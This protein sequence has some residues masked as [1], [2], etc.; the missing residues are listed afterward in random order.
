PGIGFIPGALIGG[1]IGAG[2]QMAG[3]MS[4]ITGGITGLVSTG[5][6]AAMSLGSGIVTGGLMGA[7]GIGGAAAVV[8]AFIATTV[9]NSAMFNPEDKQVGGDLGPQLVEVIKTVNKA[10]LTN[11]EAKTATVKYVIALS[12]SYAISGA[13]YSDTIT[14]IKTSGPVKTLTRQITGDNVLASEDLVLSSLGIDLSDSMVVNSVS[15]TGNVMEDGK[16]TAFGPVTGGTTV[17]IGTAPAI[18]FSCPLV[19]S[20]GIACVSQNGP[21]Q[22]SCHHCDPSYMKS[23]F[24]PACGYKGNFSAM[25]VMGQ[26]GQPVYLPSLNGKEIAWVYVRTGTD[27]DGQNSRIFKAGEYILELHHMKV[28]RTLD[29]Q[30][31]GKTL[32]SGVMVGNLAAFPSGK[33]TP[34]SHMQIQISGAWVAAETVLCK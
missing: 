5:V 29:A 21:K 34:H 20:G 22:Y 25:D 12:S 9:I 28:D 3:G 10:T 16:L 7:L 14:V 31:A 6:S 23:S 24:G 4:V 18:A 17:T 32:K 26:L 27:G 33:S 1:G 30:L 15:V 19:P 13:K 11:E 2:I 8:T